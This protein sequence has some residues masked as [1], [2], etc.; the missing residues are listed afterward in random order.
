MPGRFIQGD[1]YDHRVRR[2]GPDAYI[3]SWT[4]D[5]TYPATGHKHPVVQRRHTN[6]HYAIKFIR[7]WKLP[8]FD[9]V[10]K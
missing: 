7:K 10:Q 3:L 8:L 1:S 2:L 6:K 4:V 5:R 9:E